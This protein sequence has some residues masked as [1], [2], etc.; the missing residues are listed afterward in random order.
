LGNWEGIR[1]GED[2]SLVFDPTRLVKKGSVELP[3]RKYD[4]NLPEV[5]A[6]YIDFDELEDNAWT[7]PKGRKITTQEGI[8]YVD[9]K[10]LYDTTAHEFEPRRPITN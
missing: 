5:G 1:F 4:M 7:D 8:L 10:V 9:G 2:G 6:S 3:I